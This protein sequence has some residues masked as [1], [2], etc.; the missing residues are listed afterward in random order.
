LATSLLVATPLLASSLQV[1]NT[2]RNSGTWATR[3]TIS[4]TCTAGDETIPDGP[5]SSNPAVEPCG[6]L[7]ADD[8]DVIA[9]PVRFKAG[10]R[11]SLGDGFSVASGVSFVAEVGASVLG[12][13]V[14]R[15]ETPQALKNYHVR[16]Y[17][18]PDNL[19]LSDGQQFDHLVAYDAQGNRE[20]LIG[21]T[22]DLGTDQRRLY[23]TA[24]ENDG[25]ALTTKGFCPLTLGS[26]WQ[27]VEAHWKA[28]T[29]TDGDLEMS[30]N[31]GAIQSL[32][33]CLSMFDGLANSS[34][35][36]GA[37]EWGALDTSRGNWGSMDM[38]DFTSTQVGPIGPV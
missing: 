10:E 37:V 20:F 28:S 21:L 3:L 34:G 14:V 29:G 11:I 8:V 2:N 38:D 7:T 32:A 15:D 27:Y 13:A 19:M 25:S 31:G 36:I 4:R 1:Q 17:I 16:F 22:Y 12:D 30:V 9:G 6:V 24:F 5:L 35:E 33:S 23:M 18:D 26:G